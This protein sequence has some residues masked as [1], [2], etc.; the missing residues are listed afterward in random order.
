M[1]RRSKNTMSFVGITVGV[2]IIII[3]FL[4]QNT[5]NYSIGSDIKFGADFYTEMYD[6]TRD[7]GYVIIGLVK[8]VGWLI[9]SIGAIDVCFFGYKIVKGNTQYNDSEYSERVN[10]NHATY[11]YHDSIKPNIL[12]DV[13]VQKESSAEE[14]SNAKESS[15]ESK[16][17][18]VFEKTWV[19]G[20]CY[21]KNLNSNDT[22]W[23]CGN[24]K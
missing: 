12:E 23:S 13:S 10:N 6:V 17:N 7:I 5:S 14:L 18:Q 8:A 1:S 24:K 9:I 3:G 20:K 15:N 22:C 2:L 21:T 4:V 19:C 11:S 16:E